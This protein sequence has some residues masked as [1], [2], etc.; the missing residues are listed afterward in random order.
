VTTVSADSQTVQNRPGRTRRQLA[1]AAATIVAA[2]M[3]ASCDAGSVAKAP[4]S[5]PTTATQA[6]GGPAAAAQ[7]RCGVE[8][9][10]QPTQSELPGFMQ[11]WE[12]LDMGWPFDMAAGFPDPL[13]MNYVCGE[14]IDFTANIALSGYAPGKYPTGDLPGRLVRQN[15]HRVL[16]IDEMLYQFKS[17]TVA[18]QFVATQKP[19][20]VLAGLALAMDDRELPVSPL[21]GS[22]VSEF[23]I[24]PPTDESQITVDAPVGTWVVELYA[25][26]GTKLDWNDV[27]PYW[28]TIN[29]ALKPL[30]GTGV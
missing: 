21:P 12:S 7:R 17:A 15:P 9:S 28:T 26:G 27:Q 29:S 5:A 20:K 13:A 4:A 22:I 11:D 14:S 24:D 2:L 23:Y 6:I 30:E 10:F 19:V 25:H 8:R 3:T 16:E 18:A 1:A